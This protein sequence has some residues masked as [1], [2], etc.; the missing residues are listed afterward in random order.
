MARLCT[1]FPYLEEAGDLELP[2]VT[3]H[4]AGRKYTYGKVYCNGGSEPGSTDPPRPR[5]LRGGSTVN[6]AGNNQRRSSTRAA[7]P[8]PER[9]KGQTARA[10]R[11]PELHQERAVQTRLQVLE[12][13]A[14]LFDQRGYA[15][16]SIK[17]VADEVG[18][19]KGA[20]YFH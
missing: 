16:T 12:A 14:L 19:T 8:E 5:E 3:D 18:M 10:G 4:L 9:A 11:S 20:V 1:S 17:D 2:P 7:F 6:A 13:A 15:G